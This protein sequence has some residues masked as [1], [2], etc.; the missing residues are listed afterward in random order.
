[1]RYK[2]FCYNHIHN[3]IIRNDNK[4]SLLPTIKFYNKLDNAENSCQGNKFYNEAE[5]LLKHYSGLQGVTDKILKGLCYAYGDK[6]QGESD[7]DICNFLYYW[8]GDI[9]YN[10]LT[11]IIHFENV[12]TKLFVL[13]RINNSKNCTAPTYYSVFEK[14]PFKN[15]KLLFDYSKDYDIYKKQVSSNDMPCNKSYN[16]YLQKYVETYNMFKGKCKSERTSSR[17]CKAFK[18]YFDENDRKNLSKLTCMLHD[19]KPETEKVHAKTEAENVHDKTGAAEEQPPRTHGTEGLS[20]TLTE[21]SEGG[22]QQVLERSSSSGN[23]SS[24][25]TSESDSI[26]DPADISSNS[27]TNKTIATTVSVAGLLVPP[28][29]LY[30]VI[31]I[32]IVKLIVLFYI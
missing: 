10:K 31:S 9:L 8:L 13:L 7:I 24:E 30:N 14:E 21:G 32:T 15:I 28:F 12:I 3:L 6:F 22:G 1:M 27:T 16:V 2:N 20:V 29:L 19:N 23:P 26:P 18:E 11:N 25:G 17:Y 5:A 4:L